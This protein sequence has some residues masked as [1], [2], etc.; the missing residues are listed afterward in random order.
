[1]DERDWPVAIDYLSGASIDM[2]A[3]MTAT[4]SSARACTRTTSDSLKGPQNGV[5]IVSWRLQP[6][7]NQKARYLLIGEIG[8]STCAVLTVLYGVR[9][10]MNVFNDQVIVE[11]AFPLLRTCVS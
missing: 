10:I 1:M 6:Y 3:A 8:H 2:A 5:I 9:Q 4:T 7:Y 11:N